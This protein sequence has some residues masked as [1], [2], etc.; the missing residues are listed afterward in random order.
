MFIIAL[1]TKFYKNFIK[2]LIFN[3]PPLYLGTQYLTVH[4]IR[5]FVRHYHSTPRGHIFKG[6][7]PVEDFHQ[8]TYLTCLVR[9][10]NQKH[11]L[12]YYE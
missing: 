1:Y 9:V 10:V 4:H 7:P 5:T 12:N 11:L 2:N 6:S 8:A 3:H